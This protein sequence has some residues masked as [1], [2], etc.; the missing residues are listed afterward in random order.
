MPKA[1]VIE[2]ENRNNLKATT[3]LPVRILVY[4]CRVEAAFAGYVT[5]AETAARVSR[6][7]VYLTHLGDVV[8]W[9]GIGQVL[10]SVWGSRSC[11]LDRKIWWCVVRLGIV[12]EDMVPK[13]GGC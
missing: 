4:G 5:G 7:C 11:V 2:A 8:R 13:V 3:D 12:F 10:G 6:L 9:R 1:R